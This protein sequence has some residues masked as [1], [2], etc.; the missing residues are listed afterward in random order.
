M[1]KSDQTVASGNQSGS[2]RLRVPTVSTPASS[3][4]S[5]RDAKPVW[6]SE[7]RRMAYQPSA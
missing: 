2:T 1:P 5:I 4:H 7:A 6:P 3:T